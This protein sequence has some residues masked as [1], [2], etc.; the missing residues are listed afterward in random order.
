MKKL[1]TL[2]WGA[3]TALTAVATPAD[4]TRHKALLDQVLINP[5]P[6]EL[7]VP[8]PLGGNFSD[9]EEIGTAHFNA[10]LGIVPECNVTVY[11]CTTDPFGY[12]VDS[13]C[14]EGLFDG[15]RVAGM[16]FID[17]YNVGFSHTGINKDGQE[18]QVAELSSYYSVGME[19]TYDETL[20]LFKLAMLY[21]VDDPEVVDNVVAFGYETVQ[22]D[23]D[24]KDYRTSLEIAGETR[25]GNQLKVNTGF[26]DATDVKVNL[27]KGSFGMGALIAMANNQR[28][29]ES[30]ACLSTAD[31]V[32]F[33]L[34]EDGEY[35][36]LM[37]Y[38]A[39]E[40]KKYLSATYTYDSNWQ[41]Y[42]TADFTED[43]L[44]SY[45]DNFPIKTA[46]NLKLQ[47]HGDDEI[48]R[49]VNPYSTDD[50][51]TSEWS[52]LLIAEPLCNSY[53]AINCERDDRV[54]VYINPMDITDGDGV[55]MVFGSAAHYNIINDRTED[56]IT[57]KGYWGTITRD[58]DTA[59]IDFPQTTLMM[60]QITSEYPM[61]ANYNDAFKVVMHKS[62]GVND[63]MTDTDTNAPVEFF[64]LQG[65]R[66]NN[67]VAG[68]L[69]LRRQAGKTTKVVVR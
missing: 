58:G 39:G 5:A 31:P 59:E 14:F 28:A 26:V 29:D 61:F 52:R 30:I 50:T 38:T 21:Y 41:D 67:P 17:Y 51:W 16:P 9:W 6:M 53:L 25:V 47:K 62:A 35:T 63:I 32:Y 12:G 40:D 11:H 48:Y 66:V 54:Y 18:I 22:L 56:Q 7:R 64:N 20:G 45:Y 27:Y 42:G 44:A 60:R 68:N 34:N 49:I 3:V 10:E 65:V 23:G 43:Y 55:R 2:L 33:D 24:F 13:W 8:N 69:Y 36:A 19:T 37:T 57:E 46:Y 4:F 15:L 1:Y